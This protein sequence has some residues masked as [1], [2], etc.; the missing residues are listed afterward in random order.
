MNPR[1]RKLMMMC[2]TLHP[3]ENLDRLYESRKKEEEVSPELK[4]A[5]MH[6]FNDKR[7]KIRSAEEL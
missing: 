4:I 1:I 7:T 5:S 6:W 2:K 3:R